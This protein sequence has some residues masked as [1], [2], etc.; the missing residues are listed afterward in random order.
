M[1]NIT[2]IGGQYHRNIQLDEIDIPSDWYSLYGKRIPDTTILE[3]NIT[4]NILYFGERGETQ[5]IA[6]FDAE[7]DACSY[8]L[9][10]M[11]EYKNQLD[12]INNQPP[13]IPLKEEKRI[14]II[15]ENGDINIKKD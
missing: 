1:V 15:S 8:F 10:I 2:G 12:R 3:W 6:S 4:W 9:Q 5:N 7:N 14:F 13:Y 11:S